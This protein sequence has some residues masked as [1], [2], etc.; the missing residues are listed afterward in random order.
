MGKNPPIQKIFKKPVYRGNGINPRR[1]A[2]LHEPCNTPQEAASIARGYCQTENS[3]DCLAD[4][5]LCNGCKFQR[6]GEKRRGK[7]SQPIDKTV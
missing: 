5:P 1:V 2:T 6:A 4:K 7:Q 3:S